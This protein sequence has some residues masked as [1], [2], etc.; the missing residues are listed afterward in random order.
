M[1]YGAVAA[2]RLA[3]GSGKD[4]ESFGF[5][6]CVG[7]AVIPPPWCPL[8]GPAPDKLQSSIVQLFPLHSCHRAHR[9]VIPVFS[10]QTREDVSRTNLG[11]HLWL[12]DGWHKVSGYLWW[13]W[14]TLGGGFPFSLDFPL[15]A[16]TNR[17]GQKKHYMRKEQHKT[18]YDILVIPYIFTRPLMTL[19]LVNCTWGLPGR[20]GTLLMFSVR[21]CQL[22]GFSNEAAEHKADL[23]TDGEVNRSW[24][25]SRRCIFQLSLFLNGDF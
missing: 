6:F 12:T 11:T 16:I 23:E 10:L 18:S 25:A 8:P 3:E 22:V 14:W 17:T 1:W 20:V 9:L 24:Y 21:W 2:S 7:A 13:D 5:D 19:K 15:C 4:C